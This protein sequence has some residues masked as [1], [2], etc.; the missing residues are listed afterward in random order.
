LPAAAKAKL[1][2]LD[3]N[4]RYNDPLEWGVDVFD[5][6]TEAEVKEAVEGYAKSQK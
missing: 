3:K 4:Q 2:S 1:D 5:I 6:H